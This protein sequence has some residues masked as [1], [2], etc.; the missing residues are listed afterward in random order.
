MGKILWIYG[1][2]EVYENEVKNQK[3]L[4]AA[5][6]DVFNRNDDE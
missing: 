4:N 6:D 3:S 5:I 1:L 2:E